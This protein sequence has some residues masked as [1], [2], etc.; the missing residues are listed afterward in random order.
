MDGRPVKDGNMDPRN[1]PVLPP[2]KVNLYQYSGPVYGDLCHEIDP[3]PARS[4]CA[5]DNWNL[6]FEVPPLHRRRADEHILHR[7]RR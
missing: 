7:E 5:T 1:Q 3:W 4:F 6:L 2:E